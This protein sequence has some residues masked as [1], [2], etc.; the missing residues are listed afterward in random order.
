MPCYEHIF[1]ARPDIAAAQVE[2][3]TKQ[4]SDIITEKGGKVAN[5]EYWGLKP[6]A[7]KIKKNKKAHYVIMNLDTPHAA[8]IELERQ[9]G[10][11]E[12]VLRFMT[13]RVDELSTEPSVMMQRQPDRKPRRE[14]SDE[15]RS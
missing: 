14:F 12:D 5:T 1:I 11:H 3:M 15:G 8:L 4:F 6:L 13:I 2:E 9:E 10:I 7:Y